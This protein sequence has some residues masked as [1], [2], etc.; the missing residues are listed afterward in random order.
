MGSSHE[1]LC[2]VLP[3]PPCSFKV[4]NSAHF[5][6]SLTIPPEWKMKVVKL[7]LLLLKGTGKGETQLFCLKSF[8]TVLGNRLSL[9]WLLLLLPH[10]YRQILHCVQLFRLLALSLLCVQAIDISFVLPL[11]YWNPPYLAKK[12]QLWKKLACWM[13]DRFSTGLSS[14]PCRWFMSGTW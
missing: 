7:L 10:F 13:N 9:S 4:H 1:I 2:W 5:S 11:V 12:E 6:C 8:F 14:M 3:R